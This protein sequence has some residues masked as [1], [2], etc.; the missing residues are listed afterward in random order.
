MAKGTVTLSTDEYMKLTNENKALKE[1][2]EKNGILLKNVGWD[3]T[4]DNYILIPDEKKNELLTIAFKQTLEML[5]KYIRLNIKAQL[6][7]KAISTESKPFFF[8]PRTQHTH[9]WKK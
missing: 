9:W 5:E 4:M 6:D 2:A 3:G 8:D 1:A 7:D